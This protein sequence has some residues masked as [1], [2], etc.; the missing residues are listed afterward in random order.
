MV[1][2]LKQASFANQP[3]WSFGSGACILSVPVRP[4][5]RAD[6]HPPLPSPALLQDLLLIHWP[7]VARMD[8]TSEKNAEQR[9]AS[10]RVLE[11]YHQQARPWLAAPAHP[12]AASARHT[13][14]A[15]ISLAMPSLPALKRTI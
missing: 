15:H 2:L 3:T 10:W 8:A 11:R 9:L 5:Q 6:C 13:S 14:A 12:P 4:L 1:Q 7:G